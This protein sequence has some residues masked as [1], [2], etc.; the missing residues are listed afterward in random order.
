MTRFRSAA[1][2][3]MIPKLPLADAPRN[4]AARQAG[5]PPEPRRP[6]RTMPNIIRTSAG[7]LLR[8]TDTGHL[9][10]VPRPS[11]CMGWAN[12]CVC[13]W[14]LARDRHP[15]PA[16]DQPRQPWQPRQAA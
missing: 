5:G 2:H 6:V 10:L 12:A 1:A 7:I 4:R 9:A 15:K 16:P 13:E 11:P 8:V 3:G 14:C